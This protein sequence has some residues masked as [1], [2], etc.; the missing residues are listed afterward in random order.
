[1]VLCIRPVQIDSICINTYD[2]TIH[3]GNFLDQVADLMPNFCITGDAYEVKKNR[4]IRIRDMQQL[5][6]D[7]FPKD[8][9]EL[10]NLDLLQYND[11][12]IVTYLRQY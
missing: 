9:E 4:K 8:L 3:K 1:M 5:E 10:K 2:K 11:C 12:N 7:K 6:K